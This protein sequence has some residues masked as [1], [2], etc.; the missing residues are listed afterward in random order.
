MA[1]ARCRRTALAVSV[2]ATRALY[3]KAPRSMCRGACQGRSLAQGASVFRPGRQI[4]PLFYPIFTK[5]HQICRQ[6]A[7]VQ[8][9]ALPLLDGMGKAG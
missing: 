7:K 2:R 5:C 1:K 4:N 3:A 6:V 9:A 8:Q